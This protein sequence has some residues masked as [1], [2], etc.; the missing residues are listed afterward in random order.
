MPVVEMILKDG[1]FVA[2]RY[3][4]TD[5]V[6]PGPSFVSG[7]TMP[8]YVPTLDIDAAEKN[9]GNLSG[10]ARTEYSS[11][12]NGGV[13]QLLT[14]GTFSNLNFTNTV[15]DIRANMTFNN[16]RF[17]LTS[18]DPADSIGAMIR[19][20]NG[21]SLN[22]V[23][24]NDCEFHVRCQ[25]GMN[26]I[27]GRN[28]TFNRCIIAGGVDGISVSPSGGAAQSYGFN[29]ND[30]WIGDHPWWYWTSTGVVHPSDNHTHN[31][32][33]QVSSSLGVSVSNTFFGTWPSEFTGT[34]TPGSGSETNPWAGPY[35]T[36]QATMEGWRETFLVRET[37]ADQSYAGVS[38][39]STNGGSW[40]GIMLNQPNITV[41]HCWFSGGTVQINS[42]D[43]AL[44]GQNVGSFTRNRHWNDMTAGHSL[45]TTAKGTAIYI[46]S[47]AIITIPTTGNNRNLWFDGTTITPTI[48]P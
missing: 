25:R 5:P 24:F 27:S 12:V 16:C 21:P 31:D 8:I 42:S 43:N 23:I 9:I 26:V 30:C 4:Y 2:Y 46:H 40:A 29:I 11:T 3:G 17:T 37:R 10:I 34:G 22:N 14:A 47:T 32:G 7:E 45:T 48:K 15:V 39:W 35:I 36:D 38:K 20:L 18:Y 19:M 44:A 1:H 6:T 28:G 13:T 33:I 41:D